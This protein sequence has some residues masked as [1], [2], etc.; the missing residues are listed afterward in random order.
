MYSGMIFDNWNAIF[1]HRVRVFALRETIRVGVG[2]DDDTFNPF[3][4]SHSSDS[5]D[6]ID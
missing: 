4:V 6:G 1:L 3:A 5:G 2:G